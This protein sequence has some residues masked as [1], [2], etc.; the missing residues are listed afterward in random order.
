M[1]LNLHF[2]LK[3]QVAPQSM[4][5]NQYVKKN[6]SMLIS[7]VHIDLN[8]AIFKLM[9][10]EVG[11]IIYYINNGCSHNKKNPNH[12]LVGVNKLHLTSSK[13]CQKL[14]LDYLNDILEL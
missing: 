2:H 7:C 10:K 9:R 3:L 1:K 11:K 13:H 8:N 14:C 4:E 12:L 5:A 6:P